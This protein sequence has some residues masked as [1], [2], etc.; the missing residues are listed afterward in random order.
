MPA[1]NREAFGLGDEAQLASGSA[2][3]NWRRPK[4]GSHGSC[5]EIADTADDGVAVRDGKS[6]DS[7]PILFFS[8]QEWDAFL[9]GVKAGEFG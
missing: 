2:G 8:R 9:A 4:C 5:V 6:A 1:E 3:L 7:S